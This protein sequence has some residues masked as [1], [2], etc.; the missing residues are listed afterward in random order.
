MDI[1]GDNYRWELKLTNEVPVDLSANLG[2][3]QATLDLSGMKL[4]RLEGN[5]AVGQIIVTLPEG[6][7]YSGRLSTAIG[8]I[9]VRVPRGQAVNIR[10]ERA[11]TGVNIADGFRQD[12]NTI[13]NPSGSGTP[14]NLAINNAIGSIRVEYI[15]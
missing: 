5:A 14:V 15:R 8:E 1:R 6:S 12:G 11:I 10:L 4:T 3:G 9:V 7:G 13:T 2:A